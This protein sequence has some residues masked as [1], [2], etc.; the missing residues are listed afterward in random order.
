[1]V[2]SNLVLRFYLA[3]RERLAMADANRWPRSLQKPKRAIRVLV[4]RLSLDVRA[5][6]AGGKRYTPIDI[7]ASIAANAE[8]RDEDR[9]FEGQYPDYFRMDVKPGYRYNAKKITHEFSIDIQNV[10]QNLNVF[11][12]TYDIAAKKIKTDYQL[13]FFVIPQYRLL[14]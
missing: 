14:F 4:E 12:E 6:Y 2:M 7:E 5:T 3:A 8:V 1:M 10:T 9:A 13:K 11:Q